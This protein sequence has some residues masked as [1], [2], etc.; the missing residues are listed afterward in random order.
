[1][2]NR[3]G[4]STGVPPPAR[5][6]PGQRMG[7][8]AGAS[9]GHPA[10]ASRARGGLL[11]GPLVRERELASA[12]GRSPEGKLIRSWGFG[13][14]ERT[15]VRRQGGVRHGRRVR[16]RPGHGGAIRGRGREAVRRGR[17]SRR[18]R[19][20]ALGDPRGGRNG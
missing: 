19:A 16:Y 17:R 4:Y 10:P 11:G 13:E 12:S 9:R 5:E 6:G 1:E 3:G 7:L 15:A 18:P 8:R 2:R 14:N 20:D